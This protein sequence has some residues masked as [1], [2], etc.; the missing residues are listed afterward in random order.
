MRIYC[1]LLVLLE[2][3]K[4]FDIVNHRLL[5]QKL[6]FFFQVDTLALELI[7]SYLSNRTQYVV[8]ANSSSMDLSVCLCVQQ[9]SI[10][11]RLLFNIFIN[12]LPD[13]LSGASCHFYADDSQLI[14]AGRSADIPRLIADMNDNLDAVSFWARNNG[15]RLNAL[16]IHGKAID[17]T[18]LPSVILNGTTIPFSEIVKNLSVTFNNGGILSKLWKFAFL[19]P[20]ATLKNMMKTLLLPHYLY[21]DVVLLWR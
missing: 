4:A 8:S 16:K 13:C 5:F 2:F 10:L 3:S 19:A 21:C 12:D 20:L 18:N 17:T 14:S 6:K 15:L 11:G 1:S 9:G 7:R